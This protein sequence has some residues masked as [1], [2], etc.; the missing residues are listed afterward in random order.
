MLVEKKFNKGDVV[1]LKLVSGEELVARFQESKDDTVVV[2]KPLAMVLRVI[3]VPDGKGQYVEQT[4]VDFAPY[5][6][7]VNPDADINISK[8]QIVVMERTRQDAAAQYLKIT[9]NI[10]PAG[11]G[12]DLSQLQGLMEK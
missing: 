8:K 11:A 12:V 4:A 7:S 1:T 2:S 9:T 6:L 5:L 3:Q 10:Q